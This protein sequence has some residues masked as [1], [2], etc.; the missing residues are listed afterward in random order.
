MTLGMNQN[1]KEILKMPKFSPK[2]EK[3][4][5]LDNSISVLLSVMLIGVSLMFWPR[6]ASFNKAMDGALW[7]VTSTDDVYMTV[8]AS[9]PSDERYWDSNCNNGWIV[10]SKCDAIVSRVRSCAVN[11]ASS[12]CSTHESYIQA[13]LRQ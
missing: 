1:R 8:L 6:N 5:G 9:F 2:Q 4:K 10:N 12:Y 11:V 13:L 3:I 7:A